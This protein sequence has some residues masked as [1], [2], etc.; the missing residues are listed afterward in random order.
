DEL[1]LLR[2]IDATIE[3]SRREH[4]EWLL[5]AA[6]RLMQH[7]PTQLTRDLHRKRFAGTSLLSNIGPA[8][9][10]CHLPRIDGKLVAGNVTLQRV[11]FLPVLRAH[12]WLSFG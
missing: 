1:A 9:P 5:P 11:E 4:N 6:L 12:Q 3:R 7:F 8:L 2:H 10:H